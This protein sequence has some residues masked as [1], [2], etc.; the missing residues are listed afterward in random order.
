MSDAEPTPPDSAWVI[1]PDELLIE[2]DAHIGDRQ[3][4]RRRWRNS[5]VVVKTLSEQAEPSVGGIS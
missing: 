2:D 4:A 3:I 5:I 1:Q